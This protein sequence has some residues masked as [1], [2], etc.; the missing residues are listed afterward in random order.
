R[1]GGSTLTQQLVK[2]FFLTPER[3][4]KRKAQEALMALIVEARYDKQAILES[5]LNEIYLGQRGSTAVHGVGEA[6][7]HYFGKSAR[8]LSLSESALIAAI[9]Q[10]PN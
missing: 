5:Y 2:N 3:S 4:F 8:D 10:S 7:L 9:I 1:Q 6:S